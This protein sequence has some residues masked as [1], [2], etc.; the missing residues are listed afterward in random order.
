MLVR[1]A[2]RAQP[3]LDPTHI[4]N[5][6]IPAHLNLPNLLPAVPS[7]QPTPISSLHPFVL[8]RDLLLTRLIRSPSPTDVLSSWELRLAVGEITDG[9]DPESFRAS[10]SLHVLGHRI[11]SGRVVHDDSTWPERIKVPLWTGRGSSHR[12]KVTDMALRAAGG[13]RGRSLIRTV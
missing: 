6:R 8:L 2:R 1:S 5:H 12:H 3:I 9:V 13:L 11:W 4:F 7:F 10:A